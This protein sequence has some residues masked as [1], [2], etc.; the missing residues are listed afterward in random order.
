MKT[1]LKDKIIGVGIAATLVGSLTIWGV[2]YVMGNNDEQTVQAAEVET[3]TPREVPQN[4]DFLEFSSE[5]R[6]VNTLKEFHAFFDLKL[7]DGGIDR[8]T[9]DNH[10]AWYEFLSSEVFNAQKYRNIGVELTEIQ[11]LTIDM[12]NLSAL[13]AIARDKQDPQSL[14]YMHRILHDL[15]LYAFPDEDTI[16]GDYWGVTNTAPPKEN[17]YANFAELGNFVDKNL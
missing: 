9:P 10:E 16:K 2:T 4:V 3:K 5:S 13:V 1:R 17:E 8:F 14:V 11:G 15:D 7:T 12:S 6:A